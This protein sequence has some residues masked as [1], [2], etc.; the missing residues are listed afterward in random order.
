MTMNNL[1][2]STIAINDISGLA[3][4]VYLVK[5]IADGN[6]QLVKVIKQ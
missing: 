5:I 6:T 3:S 2:G 1:S 4:G